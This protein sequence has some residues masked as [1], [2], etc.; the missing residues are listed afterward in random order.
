MSRLLLK[1]FATVCTVYW[2]ITVATTLYALTIL[3]VGD[4]LNVYGTVSAL[5][6]S[7]LVIPCLSFSICKSSEDIVRT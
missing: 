1:F 6:S 3:T 4:A 5:I 7:A 2:V